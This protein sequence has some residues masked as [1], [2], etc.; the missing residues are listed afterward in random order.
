MP[1]HFEASLYFT[2]GGMY[3]ASRGYCIQVYGAGLNN[4][5]FVQ[6]DHQGRCAFDI[7]EDDE[8]ADCYV[9]AAN[10]V[11]MVVNGLK[12]DTP[13]KQMV[14]LRAG[15]PY[16]SVEIQGESDALWVAFRLQRAFDA[17]A[18]VV[19]SVGV[20]PPFTMK[21]LPERHAATEPQNHSPTGEFPADDTNRIVAVFPTVHDTILGILEALGLS[22][23][24][25]IRLPFVLPSGAQPGRAPAIM[26]PQPIEAAQA[27]YARGQ[28]DLLG[29]EIV[30]ALQWH[31]F[32]PER[33]HAIY[34]T[35]VG[36]I[37]T[38]LHTG[39]T[40]YEGKQTSELVAY[41]ESVADF[42]GYVIHEVA[43]LIPAGAAMPSAAVPPD[44]HRI[45][46]GRLYEQAARHLGVGIPAYAT[47]E[48]ARDALRSHYGSAKNGAKDEAA[49]AGLLFGDLVDELRA[50]RPDIHYPIEA[51]WNLM[52]SSQAMTLKEFFS[53]WPS[54]NLLP[55]DDVGRAATD[56]GII[57]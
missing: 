24:G 36:Y 16:Q 49:I 54:A 13:Y 45:A 3:P 39:P 28:Q 4:R 41:V 12:G 33:R 29:H 40:H 47:Y 9:Y 10:D 38:H 48:Q 34:Q 51:I 53:A 25:K 23:A 43:K 27:E 5:T 30:H 2:R 20:D 8:R 19:P 21:H 46:L 11:A 22:G 52:V 17:I 50:K 6:L 56:W 14:N 1:K 55:A 42:M 18:A 15:N 26:V 35:Y 31:R 32:S 7:A 37:L 57:L 44:I